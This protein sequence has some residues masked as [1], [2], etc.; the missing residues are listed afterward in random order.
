MSIENRIEVKRTPEECY[1]H[2]KV[3]TF[4]HIAR[5]W[6]KGRCESEIVPI[7]EPNDSELFSVK[8]RMPEHY[9]HNNYLLVFNVICPFVYVQAVLSQCLFFLFRHETEP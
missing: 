8:F 1:V 5:R 7:G 6:S 9:G 2:T 3:S 4:L